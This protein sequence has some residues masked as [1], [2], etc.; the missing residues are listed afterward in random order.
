MSLSLLTPILTGW[1]G[2]WV[3]NYLADV[4]PVTRRFSRPACQQCGAA[5]TWRDYLLFRP[6]AN[7][8]ARRARAWIVQFVLTAISLYIWIAPPA[9]FGYWL[10]L[11]VVI[12]FGV[13]FVIDMEHRLILHPTSL[14]GSLLGL[15]VGLVSNGF[16]PTLW[17]GLGGFV[18]MLVLYYL[19]VFFS[20]LRARRMRA[21]GQEPDDEEALGSG[22]VI[23][24]AILGFM[25]GWPLIWFGLLLGIL[26]G[27]VFGAL[28]VLFLLI[29][30][31]YKENVLMVFMPYGPF[32]IASA[33]FIMFLP[34]LIAALL[35]K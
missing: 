11:A 7:G 1:L 29:V 32:F 33:F 3:V 22:D 12:Y 13:V 9:K 21:R 10:G 15:G 31:R 28:L 27:G 2:G 26:L 23:L 16:S 30:R 17:G 35:P 6:C 8:H 5:F 24:A 34:G 25:L 14:F 4:L 20:R 19:G 18:I